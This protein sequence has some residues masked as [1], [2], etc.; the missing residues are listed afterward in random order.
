[1]SI[2]WKT[3]RLRN[4]PRLK[5]A[6]ANAKRNAPASEQSCYKRTLVEEQHLNK[7]FKKV[8]HCYILDCDNCMMIRWVTVLVL[9]NARPCTQRPAGTAQESVRSERVAELECQTLTTVE[10]G[11]RFLGSSSYSY[12]FPTIWNPS[13]NRTQKY[14][15][16]FYI[17]SGLPVTWFLPVLSAHAHRV[18]TGSPAGESR[19]S[20]SE[21][22]AKELRCDLSSQGL[23]TGNRRPRVVLKTLSHRGINF[24]F[25][26]K[27]VHKC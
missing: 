7:Y 4:C 12:G 21:P 23:T 11:G 10:S 3:G 22:K 20:H 25:Y 5:E 6:D 17:L 1:M 16:Y 9:R 8:Y 14:Y 18:A 15:E 2:P 19:T 27:L 26:S 24:S 13:Q